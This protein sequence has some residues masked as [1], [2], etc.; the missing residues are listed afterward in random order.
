M[1]DTFESRFPT[2]NGYMTETTRATYIAA[3]ISSGVLPVDA[4]RIPEILSLSAPQD[5]NSPIQFWQLF[6]I[7]GPDRI[8][9]IV[10]DFYERVFADEE[11]FTSVF[12]RVGG[13]H[14]HI[15]T[16]ASMWAD[17]MGGGPYYHGADFRLGF[18]HT[19]N[20]HQLMTEEGAKRW[21]ALMVQ[22]LD[23]TS[24]HMLDDPRVRLSINT[25]LNHFLGKYAEDFDF[26]NLETFGETNPAWQSRLDFRAMTDSD[27]QALSKEDLRFGLERRGV[28]VSGLNDKQSLV[29]KATGL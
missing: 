8:V 13:L 29:R 2:A 18:H 14:H 24:E 4:H 28:D 19:H 7:L 17:V 11:W 16:Q 3:A 10:G 1:T 9:A 12:A 22:A 25:F 27:I 20:A 5:Q 15:N 21:V 26:A 23:A 6:S